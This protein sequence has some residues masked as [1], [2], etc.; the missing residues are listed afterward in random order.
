MRGIA[1]CPSHDTDMQMEKVL[2]K[3]DLP[4]VLLD[5]RNGQV[6]A[7][8]LPMGTEE[9]FRMIALIKHLWCRIAHPAGW[10]ICGEYECPIC[11]LR[12]PVPWEG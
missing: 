2:V 5:M 9:E 6:A 3:T 12:H 8:S 10:P 7:D 4:Q 1:R 11:R